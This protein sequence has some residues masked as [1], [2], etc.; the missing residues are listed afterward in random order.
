MTHA[1]K[2]I[3]R[4]DMKAAR[5]SAGLTQAAAARTIEHEPDDHPAL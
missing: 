3:T 2:R 1:N 4:E 5:A